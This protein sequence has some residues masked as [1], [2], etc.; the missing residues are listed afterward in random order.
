MANNLMQRSNNDYLSLRD[1]MDRLFDE[2]FLR[3]FGNGNWGSMDMPAVDVSETSDKVV[4]KAT[5]P[6]IK[7]DDIKITLTGDVLQI[8]GEN[9]AESEEDQATYH[10]RE[11]RSGAF[12]RAISI[13]GPVMADKAEAHFENGVLTLTL[14][15]A[16]EIR[17]KSIKIS[18]K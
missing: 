2:S 13:P 17:P 10:V 1:A 15:K 7:P 5:V 6:G 9:E 4:V 8:S 3:P 12:S 16:E 11:R 18:T 14:P